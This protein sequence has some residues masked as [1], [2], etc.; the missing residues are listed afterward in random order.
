[1]KAY[2][3]V[4]F[5]RALCKGEG[6]PSIGEFNVQL[7]D[8]RSFSFDFQE[9]LL[10]LDGAFFSW[11]LKSLDPSFDNLDEF[12]KHIAE[13][14]KINECYI[15]TEDC[16]ITEEGKKINTPLIPLSLQEFT[17][18]DN[19]DLIGGTMDNGELIGGTIPESTN[20]V[21]V[22]IF[23]ESP[24]DK[25]LLVQYDF[26]RALLSAYNFDS[27]NNP[28]EVLLTFV[29]ENCDGCGTDISVII[30]ILN[31]ESSVIKEIE[32]ALHSRKKSYGEQ[33][34]VNS[35]IYDVLTDL[36]IQFEFVSTFRTTRITL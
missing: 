8:G 12:R 19:G 18:M 7:K 31:Q 24:L 32:N 34:N 27:N 4:L 11:E 25:D 6:F 14:V 33:F 1:M 23:H 2:V 20:F 28:N 30:K 22:E 9:S 3:S 10:Y 36:D 35:I 5:N 15:D 29:K 16:N 21:E 13:I 17:I 26:K